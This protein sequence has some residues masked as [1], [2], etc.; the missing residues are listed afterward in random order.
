MRTA[1]SRIHLPGEATRRQL[2]LQGTLLAFTATVIR[3][4]SAQSNS[5]QSTAISTHSN[6]KKP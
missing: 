2:L 5:V 4:V 3:S 1:N 6:L